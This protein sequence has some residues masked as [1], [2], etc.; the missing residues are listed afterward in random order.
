MD[1]IERRAFALHLILLVI[2]SAAIADRPTR[3]RFEKDYP[4]TAVA[5]EAVQLNDSFWAPRLKANR[6]SGVPHC[7]KQLEE[8]GAIGMFRALNGSKKEP[9][10]KNNPWGCSDVYKSFEA[11]A[12]VH[13]TSEDKEAAGAARKQIDEFLKLVAGAQADDGFIFPYLQLYKKGYKPFS[14]A[15]SHYTETYCMGH[16]IEMAVEHYEAT[17]SAEAINVANSV[18]DCIASYHG[19]DKKYDIPSGHPEIE[20]ALMRLYRATGEAKH[21]RLAKYLVEKA[22]TVKTTWSQGRP[23]LGH[24]EAVGHTVAMFYLYAGMADVAQVSGNK[25]LMQ[26]AHKKWDDAA[27]RKTYITGNAGHRC[28]RAEKR[29]ICRRYEHRHN[30]EAMPC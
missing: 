29:P 17:G 18:S 30:P 26:L 2:C 22:K 16:L 15:T 5:I 4:I 11:L 21:L 19:A 13:R 27:G 20:I 7:L 14:S 24:D 8:S 9:R 23:A 6:L 10:Y 1:C 28:P 3:R 25:A 12:R